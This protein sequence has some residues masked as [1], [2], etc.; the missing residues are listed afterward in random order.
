MVGFVDDGRLVTCMELYHSNVL[1]VGVIQLRAPPLRNEAF[2]KD[3]LDWFSSSGRSG[4]INMINRRNT[5]Y[6]YCKL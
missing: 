1:N 2:V 6:P 5:F 4:L 3:F